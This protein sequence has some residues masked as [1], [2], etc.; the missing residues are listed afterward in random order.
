M[1]PETKVYRQI[2]NKTDYW[3]LSFEEKYNLLEHLSKDLE[4]S[5][6]RYKQRNGLNEFQYRKAQIEKLIGHELPPI[7]RK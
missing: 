5:M 7:N 3:R 4:K 1:K 6:K 2:S